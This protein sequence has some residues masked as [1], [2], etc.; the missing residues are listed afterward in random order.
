MNC[1]PG[2][3]AISVN[4][5]LPENEGRIVRVLR[6]HVNDETWNYGSRP[7]WWCTSPVP[8]VW[9][10][11]QKVIEACEGPIPDDQLRPIRPPKSPEPQ[12]EAEL[13]FA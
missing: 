4:C 3:L 6:R 10:V 8:M 7:A 2:D 13:D 12:R 9:T 5:M 1:Q 11:R